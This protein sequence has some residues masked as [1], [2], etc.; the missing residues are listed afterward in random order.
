ME[1]APEAQTPRTWL[2]TVRVNWLIVLGLTIF[3]VPSVFLFNLMDGPFREQCKQKC[4]SQNM[5]YRVRAVRR[6]DPEEYPADCIC[7][8]K[9]TWWEFWK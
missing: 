9:S 5:D 2:Q 7:I 1:A 4:L 6:A 3:A 8:P